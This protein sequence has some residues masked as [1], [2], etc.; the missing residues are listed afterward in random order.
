[1][2][3]SAK[4]LALKIVAIGEMEP[5]LAVFDRLDRA[6]QHFL[7]SFANGCCKWSFTGLDSTAWGVDLPGSKATLLLDE[8]HLIAPEDEAKDGYLCSLPF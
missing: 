7:F 3:F 4:D 8:Q 2:T 5:E 1:V 6:H